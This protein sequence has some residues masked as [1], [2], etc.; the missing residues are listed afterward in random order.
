MNMTNYEKFKNEI[1]ALNYDFGVIDTQEIC[2]CWTMKCAD[3][4]F[5][6]S[7]ECFCSPTKVRWL[8][9]EFRELFPI[10]I[11][12]K[13]FLEILGESSYIARDYNGQ[14]FIYSIEPTQTSDCW[15]A[16]DEEDI[17]YEF[18]ICSDFFEYITWES[19]KCWSV[20]EL[21]EMPVKE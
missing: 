11:K 6:T 19:D 4:I 9:E 16:G 15:I 14:L 21:L 8:Y 13:H 17:G 3:C 10:T 7:K 5:H 12:E 18:E 1:E 20:A 2:S